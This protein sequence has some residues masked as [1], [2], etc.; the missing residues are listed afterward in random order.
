[1]IRWALSPR[2]SFLSML[3]LYLP[4]SQLHCEAHF[5]EGVKMVPATSVTGLL[6]VGIDNPPVPKTDTQDTEN[7][8]NAISLDQ[9]SASMCSLP[10]SKHAS[11]K[12][13]TVAPPYIP[14][15]VIPAL[16]RDL[17]RS[18]VHN[19]PR[20]AK[21]LGGWVRACHWQAMGSCRNPEEEDDPLNMQVTQDGNL[22]N[23]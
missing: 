3:Y 12:W 15:T 2:I 8:D 19:L 16:T 14:N 9:E 18:K 20:L 17:S 4:P 23:F 21:R 6:L 22:S 11:T 1:M 10:L 7:L 13:L 5:P